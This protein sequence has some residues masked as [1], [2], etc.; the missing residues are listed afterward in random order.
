MTITNNLGKLEEVPCGQCV[1]CRL[2]KAA[3]WA[4]RCVHEASLYEKNSFITLTYAPK[5]LPKDLSINKND[6]KNFIRRLRRHFEPKN[7]CDPYDHIRYYACGEYGEK[8]TKRPHYHAL[9][10]N[11]DFNDKELLR[12]SSYR[13]LKNHFQKGAICDLYKSKTLA[14]IWPYGFSTIGE[15]TLDSA[16]Y[17]ARYVMKKITGDLA[18]EHYKQRT[19]EF[20]LMS[21]MPGIGKPFFDKYWTDIYPKDYFHINGFKKSPPRYYDELLF[22]INPQMLRDIKDKRK[23]NIIEVDSKRQYQQRQIKEK[24]IKTTLQRSLE[25]D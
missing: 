8:G 2:Q 9:L 5:F 24:L 23:E 22:K 25:N 10:F 16:G 15:V 21:R 13:Q 20:A 17:V 18:E 14:K 11:C 7:L 3:H 19:P 6:L 1:D 4:C 12:G